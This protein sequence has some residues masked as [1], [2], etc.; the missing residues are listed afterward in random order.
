MLSQIILVSL[1][2]LLPASL[3]HGGADSVKDDVKEDLDHWNL[4]SRCYSEEKLTQW[5]LA[6][7]KAYKVCEAQGVPDAAVAALT[8]AGPDL[9]RPVRL[10]AFPAAG[11]PFA[12]GLPLAAFAPQGG[13]WGYNPYQV[14]RQGFGR[15][16][17]QAVEGGLLQPTPEEHAEF[18][19]Q[20]LKL[21]DSMKTKVGN[22]SCVLTALNLLDAAG[23]VNLDHYTVEKWEKLGQSG[24]AKDPA[25][26]QKMKD[27]YIE[28]Y[29][30]AQAWPQSVLDKKG[31]LAKQWGRQMAFFKCAKKLEVKTCYQ[32]QIK[33]RLE[34]MYGPMD[35]TKF[36]D[37]NGDLYEAATWA[38]D[39]KEEMT[40]PEEKTVYNFL[41]RGSAQ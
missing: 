6:C 25:F 36:A 32:A 28:C 35:P 21:K 14:A 34:T 41:L 38:L 33:T 17:R 15:R 40:T 30:V 23:N 24:Y 20:G 37:F 31:P 39:V 3:V 12:S 11:S 7:H 2:V 19:R 5:F 29:N 27:G 18:L 16:R 10:A 1:C 4:F 26:V 13:Y 8:D 22:L 9:N